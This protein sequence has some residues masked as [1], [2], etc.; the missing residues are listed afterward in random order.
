MRR[1]A[2]ALNLSLDAGDLYI[3]N[4]NRLHEVPPVLGS[5]DRVALGSFLGYSANELLVWG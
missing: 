1:T 3:F 2:R 4:S 5:R